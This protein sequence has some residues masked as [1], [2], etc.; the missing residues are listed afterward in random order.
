M[1]NQKVPR[2]TIDRYPNVR[3][4]NLEKPLSNTGGFCGAKDNGR[5]W[6]S[7]V[8]WVTK[9]KN[10]CNYSQHTHK[11]NR[12]AVETT[13]ENWYEYSIFVLVVETIFFFLKRRW[14]HLTTSESTA[15]G[16]IG[17]LTN[18]YLIEFYSPRIFIT[19]ITIETLF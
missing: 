15:D 10:K 13:K 2:L 7:L 3:L 12:F 19:N 9:I 11:K 18:P 16:T 14:V 8:T 5:V 4:Y 6:R 17:E 1:I